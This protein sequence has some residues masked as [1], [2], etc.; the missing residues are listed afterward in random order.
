MKMSFISMNF[1]SFPYKKL[2][3]KT[4]YETEA[5]ELK[6]TCLEMPLDHHHTYRLPSQEG[7]GREE[8]QR[9]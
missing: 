6:A 4:R 9:L 5:G 8:G 7:E 1:L 3:I 2:C